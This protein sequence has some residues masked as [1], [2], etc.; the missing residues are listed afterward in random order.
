[1]AGHVD[2]EADGHTEQEAEATI[3]VAGHHRPKGTRRRDG[4]EKCA[5]RAAAK[6]RHH[7]IA[8]VALLDPMQPLLAP[9]MNIRTA[10][11]QRAA[12][13]TAGCGERNGAPAIVT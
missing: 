6:H 12:T 2:D 1:M 3:R 9:T 4:P 10:R 5:N 11:L 13:G 7:Q 8:V